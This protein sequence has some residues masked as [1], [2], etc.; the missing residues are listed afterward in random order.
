MIIKITTKPFYNDYFKKIV[1]SHVDYDKK[2]K[3][4][5]NRDR[6]SNLDFKIINSDIKKIKRELK[7]NNVKLLVSRNKEKISIYYND[8]IV[9]NSISNNFKIIEKHT[10][11]N[12]EQEKIQKNNKNIEV[13]N[14]LYN[15]KYRN[16]VFLKL[17]NRWSSKNI[18]IKNDLKKSLSEIIDDFKIN[19]SNKSNNATLVFNGSDD[20]LVYINMKYEE[21]IVSIKQIILTSEIGNKN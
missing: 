7:K 1:I 18:E 19:H 14:I 2:Y 9:E 17:S 3:K 10:P 15:G 6:F 21:Y 16:K 4:L 11:V 13:R 5:T 8:D 12:D 20:I